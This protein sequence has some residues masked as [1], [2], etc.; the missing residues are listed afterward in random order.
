MAK[1][2]KLVVVDKKMTK[3][4]DKVKPLSGLT[5]SYLWSKNGNKKPRIDGVFYEIGYQAI[6]RSSFN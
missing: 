1:S 2:V 5:L 6:A 3:R 4:Y